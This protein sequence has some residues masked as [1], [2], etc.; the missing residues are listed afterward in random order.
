MS[1]VAFKKKG[2]F[3]TLVECTANVPLTA[4]FPVYTMPFVYHNSIFVSSFFC[5][6]T[7]TAIMFAA[8]TNF[9][10]ITLCF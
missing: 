7:F 9:P 1:D 8:R 5:S 4:P 2:H 3:S 10:V 6:M